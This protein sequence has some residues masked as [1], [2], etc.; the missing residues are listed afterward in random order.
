[1][2][3]IPAFL[4]DRRCKPPMQEI[5]TMCAAVTACILYGPSTLAA[6]SD[7][8]RSRPSLRASHFIVHCHLH[9]R[10]AMATPKRRPPRPKTPTTT[11]TSTRN[12][13]RWPWPSRRK[14]QR[15]RRR[16]IRPTTTPTITGRKKT[17]VSSCSCPSCQCLPYKEMNL[18]SRGVERG[19]RH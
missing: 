19:G 4:L 2:S 14:S 9:F 3:A 15:R 1:M 13:R 6:C 7:R 16:R 17:M 12:S 8:Q 18:I 5:E 10:S 11:T